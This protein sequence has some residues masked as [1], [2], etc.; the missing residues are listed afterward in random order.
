MKRTTIAVI[1][2]LETMFVNSV[3]SLV[4]NIR[5]RLQGHLRTS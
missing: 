4:L 2:I 3:S 1:R 5:L